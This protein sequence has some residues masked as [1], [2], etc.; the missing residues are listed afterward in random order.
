M[1]QRYEAQMKLFDSKLPVCS[2][3]PVR[4]KAGYKY[5]FSWEKK[6]KR[7]DWRVDGYRWRQYSTVK[8]N[9][10]GVDCKRYYFKL[11]IGPGNDYT[12][13]FTRHAIESPSYDKKV[14]VW[15]QGD[16]SVIVD[17]AHSH[18]KSLDNKQ[19]PE[20]TQRYEAQM[21]LFDSESNLPM[22][23]EVPIRPKGGFK[24]I[25]KWEDALKRQDWRVDGYRWRQNSTIRFTYGGTDCKRYYFKLQ[26]GPGDE[27]TTEFT[28]HA[29]ECPLFE[30]KVLVWYQGDESVVVDFAHGNSKDPDKEFHR[31][32]P[33][34]LT[35][36][37]METD[38]LP[39]QLYSD[40]VTAAPRELERHII[41]A[42][43]DIKQVQNAR[44]LARKAERSFNATLT[45]TTTNTPAKTPTNTP[46][47]AKQ[48]RKDPKQV[49]TARKFTR[50]KTDR[51]PLDAIYNVYSM[52]A[53]TGFVSDIHFFPSLVVICF[54]ESK[55][56]SCIIL[57]RW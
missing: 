9:Y 45:D 2:E 6:E 1:T 11:Q 31:T 34:V 26:V 3:V 10:D 50:H 28:K 52:H 54:S 7:Q 16:E 18:A 29:I 37:K 33:S 42:P 13:D 56:L 43:R 12:T 38:K 17:S 48:V 39:L 20:V 25:F 40:L 21:K 51:S 35:K 41:D 49:Q 22:H 53:E 44:K 8:F 15:Y 27:F 23:S 19:D 24:Y 55:F 5:I 57:E 47:S 46:A 32:A 30:N 4:P 36:M 14:L